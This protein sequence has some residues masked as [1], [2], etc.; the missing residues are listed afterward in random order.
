M[1]RHISEEDKKYLSAIAVFIC[2]A[3]V[4]LFNMIF[5]PLV[6]L[7]ILL[8]FINNKNNAI[9]TTESIVIFL[10]AIPFVIYCIIARL[11][12]MSIG[13]FAALPAAILGLLI[14]IYKRT[15]GEGI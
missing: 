2:I 5:A 9:T 8:Y 10:F 7:A 1:Y 15:R 4:V 6:L 14:I 3:L 13:I 12:G 11:F